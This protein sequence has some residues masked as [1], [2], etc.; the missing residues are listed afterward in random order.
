MATVQ[1]TVPPVNRAAPL[2]GVGVGVLPSIRAALGIAG[3][4][5]LQDIWRW[6]IYFLGEEL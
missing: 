2:S 4:L 3:N 1:L 5:C 6:A